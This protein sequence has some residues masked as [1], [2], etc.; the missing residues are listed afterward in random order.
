MKAI[1][2]IALLASP[3][4]II[5]PCSYA[6]A[7]PTVGTATGN[8][9][10]CTNPSTAPANGAAIDCATCKDTFGLTTTT[11]VDCAACGAG[12]FVAASVCG[13]CH[14]SCNMATCS[15]ADIGKCRTCNTG[16]FKTGATESTVDGTCSA[17]MSNC[18]SCTSTASCNT[19]NEGF[20]PTAVSGSTPASCT[21]C[22]VSGCKVCTGAGQCTSCTGALLV[23]A[24]QGTTSAT[25]L[26]DCT[27]GYTKKDNTCQKNTTSSAGLFSA[28]SV[29]FLAMIALLN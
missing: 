16:F 19:C 28:L 24:M 4:F 20:Y 8:C 23:T 6:T 11:P 15:G 29:A 18:A 13:S 14:T 9:A 10:T 5:A 7:T 26:A 17:C 12:K 25:C 2:L 22:S 27:A 1:I 21:I 3:A